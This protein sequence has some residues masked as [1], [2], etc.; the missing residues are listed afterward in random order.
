MVAKFAAALTCLLLSV[1]AASIRKTSSSSSVIKDAGSNIVPPPPRLIATGSG[2]VGSSLHVDPSLHKRM[3]APSQV[4]P[5][6]AA[7]SD[8]PSSALKDLARQWSTGGGATSVSQTTDGTP[9][10]QIPIGD[11]SSCVQVFTGFDCPN[12]CGPGRD[13]SIAVTGA[14]RAYCEINGDDYHDFNQFDRC[15]EGG[16]QDDGFCLFEDPVNEVVYETES[17]I[18]DKHCDDGIT[19]GSYGPGQSDSLRNCYLT[20]NGWACWFNIPS[21]VQIGATLQVGTESRLLIAGLGGYPFSSADYQP[22]NSFCFMVL[23]GSLEPYSSAQDSQ[24]LCSSCD[25]LNNDGSTINIAFD[26]SNL[27]TGDCVG[28]DQSGN[29]ISNF[30]PTTPT[31]PPRVPTTP[32]PTPL[33][34]PPSAPSGGQQ[35]LVYRASYAVNE[36]SIPDNDFALAAINVADDVVICDVDVQVNV[37]HTYSGDLSLVL[38]PPQSG[39]IYNVTLVERQ[40]AGDDNMV[41][42]FDDEALTQLSSDVSCQDDGSRVQPVTPL[43]VFDGMSS[44]GVWVL[45]IVD[46]AAGDTGYLSSWEVIITP[47]S[48]GN[49]ASPTLP[50]T[51]PSA[52]NGTPQPLVYRASYA[53]NE[54]SIPDSDV[55]GASIDITD[56]IVV[57][58]VDIMVDVQHTY[59]GD[60]WLVLYYPQSSDIN[61]TLAL[62]Q[63]AG[64]DNV[65]EYF[66]DEALVQLGTDLSCQDG[67]SRVQ[68]VTPLSVFDGRSSLGTWVLGIADLADGDTGYLSSWEII[69]TPC[70]DGNPPPPTTTSTFPPTRRPIT[71]RPTPMPSA[72]T[73]RPTLRP[74]PTPT[75]I[76][77][78]SIPVTER[79]TPRPSPMP[80]PRPTIRDTEAPSLRPNAGPTSETA[81]PSGTNRDRDIGTNNLENSSGN[82]DNENMVPI[83]AGAVG[84]AAVL[85]LLIVG[86]VLYRKKGDGNGQQ[87]EQEEHV[88][89][90]AS[91]PPANELS[92]AVVTGAV[93]TTAAGAAGPSQVQQIGVVAPPGRLGLSIAP[94][95]K[96]GNKHTINTVSSESPLVGQ[97]QEGD[98]VVSVDGTAVGTMTSTELLALIG[99]KAEAERAFVLERSVPAQEGAFDC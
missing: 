55:T 56:D 35:P 72:V 9:R 20:A 6:S 46:S 32:S 17:D 16:F 65:V 51:F 38:F 49:P 47:C 98:V 8:S 95:E 22:D 63:C 21:P 74:T 59:S 15:V 33:P 71:P 99:S 41:E 94:D 23:R 42:Y 19:A 66:D 2:D 13:F 84:G 28:L 29:C 44:F 73:D 62:Q 97:V 26:C 1:E 3:L 24:Y 53:V 77:S 43:S 37:Q 36:I 86:F 82:D 57:C 52:P 75:A 70:S 64:D 27:L 4:D 5:R 69:I 60:L 89:P 58:D 76:P 91:S 54:I 81:S 68:P 45:G 40:C 31:I 48:D 67:G 93:A 96:N 12:I 92:A 18:C 30:A 61:A 87:E 10:D 25:I 34:T 7:A 88:V 83:I 78:A 50:P 90:P 85:I 80:T 39:D 14:G 79:P 11:L